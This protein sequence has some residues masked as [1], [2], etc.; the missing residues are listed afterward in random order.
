MLLAVCGVTWGEATYYLAGSFNEWSTSANAFTDNGNGSYTITTTIGDNTTFKVFK[1]EGETTTWLGGASEGETSY[2]ITYGNHTN[3]ALV[4]GN[5]FFIRLGGEMTFTI[6]TDMTLTVDGIVPYKLYGSF[7]EWQ[8]GVP[9]VEDKT[10]GLFNATQALSGDQFKIVDTSGIWYGGE[11]D[12]DNYKIHEGWCTD[13][14]LKNGKNFKIEEAGTYTFTLNPDNMTLTVRG[15]KADIT[16]PSSGYATYCNAYALDF[17]NSGAEVFYAPNG[18]VDNQVKLEKIESGLVP[19][20]TGI[21]VKGTGN[22]TVTATTIYS[23]DELTGNKLVGVTT[24]T[25]LAENQGY[26]LKNG[27]FH[28]CSGGTLKAGKAYLAVEVTNSKPLQVAFDNE[29]GTP[30]AIREIS[31]QSENAAIYTLGGVR[32]KKAEKGVYIINGKKV[33]K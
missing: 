25:D 14:T 27:E 29:E 31:N 30:T 28:P 15:W 4:N 18:I 17:S 6:T 10:T 1:V 8:A 22:G 19:A 11:T 16:L 3:I 5:N 20:A 13:I 9:F 2:Y 7:D 24:D 12:D 23:A 21:I 32:V 26:V 33:V